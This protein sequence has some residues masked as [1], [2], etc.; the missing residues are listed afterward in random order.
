MLPYALWWRCFYGDGYS[1]GRALPMTE[2]FRTALITSYSG[3]VLVGWI[4]A[5]GVMS[6]V[7]LVMYPAMQL[8]NRQF[9]RQQGSVLGSYRPEIN[10]FDPVQLG[11]AALKA[12]LILGA[13]LLLLRWL[14]IPAIP[15]TDLNQDDADQPSDEP[16]IS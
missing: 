5:Q 8:V 3:A 16:S 4:L 15:K 14:Y 13:G 10:L 11:V 1:E 2:R 6:G 9:V 12:A 7:G